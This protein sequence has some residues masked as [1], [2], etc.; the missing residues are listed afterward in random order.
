MKFAVKNANNKSVLTTHIDVADLLRQQVSSKAD[1]AE[2]VLLKMQAKQGS[3]GGKEECAARMKAP[4]SESD[5]VES[6][7]RN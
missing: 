2:P 4:P 6:P 1:E 7:L 5:R 3:W